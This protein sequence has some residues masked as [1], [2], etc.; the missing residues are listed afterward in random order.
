VLLRAI[1]NSQTSQ[2]RGL[3]GN[4]TLSLASWRDS[5]LA[6]RRTLVGFVCISAGVLVGCGSSST[7]TPPPADFNLSITPAQVTATLGTASPTVSVSVASL[8]GFSGSVT[9]TLSGVP[10]GLTTQPAGPFT[11]PAGGSQAF[12]FS[13]PLSSNVGVFSVQAAAASGSI[14]HSGQISLTV[15]PEITLSL[16]PQT[17]EA[18]SSCKPRPRR[19]PCVSACYKPGVRPSPKSA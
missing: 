15:N 17:T 12:D 6:R 14:S 4:R 19:T 2:L 3:R 13:V 5:A 9:L 7:H 10:A 11:I 16:L 18:N 8:N 1:L